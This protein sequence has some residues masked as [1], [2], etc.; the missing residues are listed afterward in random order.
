MTNLKA[1]DCGNDQHYTEE[2]GLRN[3]MSMTSEYNDKSA[4]SNPKCDL[5]TAFQIT[6]NVRRLEFVCFMGLK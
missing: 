2:G 4:Q 1:R 3:L 5:Q 6:Q